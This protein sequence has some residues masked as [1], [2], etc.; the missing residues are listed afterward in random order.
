MVPNQNHLDADYDCG[1]LKDTMNMG[2][3][4]RESVGL[5]LCD[6]ELVKILR[7]R[8]PGT[9]GFRKRSQTSTQPES[10]ILAQSERWRQA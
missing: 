4:W 2:L 6:W 8:T 10:L 1:L 9:F 7:R 5:D 3:V